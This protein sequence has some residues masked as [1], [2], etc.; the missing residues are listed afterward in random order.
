MYVLYHIE[1]TNDMIMQQNR[2][3]TNEEEAYT[4][5]T[6]L[7]TNL[8]RDEA[9]ALVKQYNQEEFHIVHLSLIHI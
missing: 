3:A 6:T 1:Y 5:V 2:P 8:T 4:M 9:F 7:S